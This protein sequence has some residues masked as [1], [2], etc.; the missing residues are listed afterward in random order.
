M[1][2]ASAW[3]PGTSWQRG[4]VVS[5]GPYLP[6]FRLGEESKK[7]WLTCRYGYP[8][9]LTVNGV[10]YDSVNVQSRAF[11][12]LEF[13][14]IG[15]TIYVYLATTTRSKN[16]GPLI[17][18]ALATVFP[19]LVVNVNAAWAAAPPLGG[20]AHVVSLVT[21]GRYAHALR[22]V[23]GAP[24][25]SVHPQEDTAYWREIDVESEGPRSWCPTD[26]PTAAKVCGRC[27]NAV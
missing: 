1:P 20:I 6:T 2:A 4:S 17:A 27:G 3:A 22:D 18:A 13:D 14:F 11:D 12:A 9:D 5:F 25:V 26:N 8:E 21:G 24:S 7:L 16:A 10:A 19:N 15:T 23:T